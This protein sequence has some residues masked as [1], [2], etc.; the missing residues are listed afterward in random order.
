MGSNTNNLNLYKASPVEDANDTFNIE[1]MLNENWDKVDDT[2]GNKVDLQTTQKDN[3]VGAINEVKTKADEAFQAGVD[4]KTEVVDALNSKKTITAST[5][6]DLWSALVQKIRDIKEGS[7]N[8]L[9]VDVLNGKTFTNNDGTEYTGTMPNN[10]TVTITPGTMNKTISQGYHNGSG[11]VAGDSDLVSANIKAGKNIFGVAGNSNVVDTSAGD[12]AASQIISGKKAYADGTLVTGTMAN[13][14]TVSIT[15]GTTN[16]SISQGYHSGSGYVIGDP[17]LIS[18]NIKAGKNIFGVAGS[19]NVVDTSAGDAVAS[20]ILSGKKAY[21]D[22]ELIIGSMPNKTGGYT[23]DSLTK[24]G[25]E[26]RMSID[27]AGY[28]S[29]GA[30]LRYTDN[31]WV[32]ANI[33]NGVNIFG[34]VGTLNEGLKIAQGT[35]T[36]P[37]PDDPWEKKFTLTGLSFRP[38]YV[39]LSVKDDAHVYFWDIVSDVFHTDSISSPS[40]KIVYDDGFYLEFSADRYLETPVSW[41]VFG[42]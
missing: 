11:Y 38:K 24:S 31:D 17:D 21:V 42:D 19:S 33:K 15:P 27:S 35:T 30:Y 29:D 10:G 7:G 13:N 4:R 18:A 12:A 20:H 40:A 14:G 34:K 37:H 8:A 22:G 9:K 25:N 16:K 6:A 5:I 26:L 32:E 41:I 1:T 39:F 28:F 23:T 36:T 3:L 2:V